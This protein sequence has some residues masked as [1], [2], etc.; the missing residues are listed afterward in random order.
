MEKKSNGFKV[1]IICILGVLVLTVCVCLIY[2]TFFKD[3]GKSEPAETSLATSA[4]QA[5][6]E[7]K[8]EAY[9][10]FSWS[11]KKNRG[12]TIPMNSDQ[13]KT[14]NFGGI[15]SV[16]LT[17]DGRAI[18]HCTAELGEVYGLTHEVESDVLRVCACPYG[19][20]GYGAVF[21]IMENG[22]VEALLPSAIINEYKIE[23]ITDLGG[24]KEVV[25]VE[26][27]TEGEHAGLVCASDI[28]G[29]VTVLDT[30]LQ[31]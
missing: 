5:Q 8:S 31:K 18:L 21:F 27:M 20:G 23:K 7:G 26:R 9:E 6:T 30:Y 4:A 12:Y 22:S 28:N 14:F 2:Q 13:L 10:E 29:N 1:A 3:S 16:E 11:A 19:N 17:S 25:N 15:E 24:A